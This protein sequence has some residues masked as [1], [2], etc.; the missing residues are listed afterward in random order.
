[1]Y[2]YFIKRFFDFTFT[3]VALFCLSPL[4]VIVMVLLYFVNEGAG[5]FFSQERPGNDG[6]IVNIFKFQSMNE[7]SDGDGLLLPDV[8]RFSTAGIFIS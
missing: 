6:R 7:Q 2:R 5:V 8:E 1:M 4:F 3:L